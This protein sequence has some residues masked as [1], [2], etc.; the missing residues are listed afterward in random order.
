MKE[1]TKGLLALT[2]VALAAI[3]LIEVALSPWP[4]LDR[5]QFMADCVTA[6]G[7]ARE[8]QC[9]ADFPAYEAERQMG[10]HR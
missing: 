8:G 2:G 4:E 3:I 1:R 10:W 7:I 6:R 5:R 9:A